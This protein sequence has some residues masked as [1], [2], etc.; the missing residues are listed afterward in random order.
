MDEKIPRIKKLESQMKERINFEGKLVDF[1]LKKE[2]KETKKN[3]KK[4]S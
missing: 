3:E 1:L 4:N 2:A